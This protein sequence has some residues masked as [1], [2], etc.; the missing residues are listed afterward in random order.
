MPHDNTAYFLQVDN[1]GNEIALA[2]CSTAHYRWSIL[3]A[4]L[5]KQHYFFF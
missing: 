5:K 4:I 1:L 3:S 2:L